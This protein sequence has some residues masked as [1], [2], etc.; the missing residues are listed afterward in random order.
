MPMPNPYPSLRWWLL[1]LIRSRIWTVRGIEHLPT[2]GGFILAANHQSWLDSAILAAA[3]YRR[4]RQPLKFVSQSKRYGAFGGL[5]IDPRHRSQV[6]EVAV[7]ALNEGFPL[8]IFPEGNSNRNPELRVGKTGVA[9]LALRTGLPVVPVGIRGTRGVA[10]WRAAIWFFALLR[11]CYVELGRPLDYP[12]TEVQADES[13]L[14][15]VTTDEI[16]RQISE[17]SGKPMSGEGPAGGRASGWRFILWRLF[18]PVVQWRIRINGAEHLPVA[19]PFI[20]AGN[21]RSYFDAPALSM[22]VFHVTGLQTMYPTKQ[23]VADS[24]RRLVGLGGL[25]ALGMLPLDNTD[26]GKVL[27]PAI[28]YLQHGGVIGIFPEGTRNKPA[29]NPRWQ[30][31]MLKGKTGAVRLMIATGAPVVPA[32]IKAPPGLSIITSIFKG[33]L[34]WNFIR[35]TFGPPITF[36]DVPRSLAT[37]TKNDLERLT[38]QLMLKLSDLTGLKYPY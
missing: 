34:P 32:A 27:Q 24:F 38:R 30:T 31:D 4:L 35:V 2:T 19:G 6:L 22:A 25:E 18:R 37:T 20:V 36:S 16:L 7:A 3:V 17:L 1:P 10:A 14:L 29:I 23:S 12:R 26:R 8:V 21:H 11:P 33:L 28:N 13:E 15:H 5:T 9:R